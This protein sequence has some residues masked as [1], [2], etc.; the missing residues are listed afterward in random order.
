MDTKARLAAIPRQAFIAARCRA[1]PFEKIGSS[2]FI[3]RAA[4]KLACLDALFN[5]SG[6]GKGVV[7][8]VGISGGLA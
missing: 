8:E 4:V 3:N 5:L 6:G 2:V 1:N 7:G